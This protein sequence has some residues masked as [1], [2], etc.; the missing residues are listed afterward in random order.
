MYGEMGV[1]EER[2][3][4]KRKKEKKKNSM[5]KRDVL[6]R[7]ALFTCTL[8]FTVGPPRAGSASIA[9]TQSTQHGAQ[10]GRGACAGGW[11]RMREQ[12]CAGGSRG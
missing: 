8:T 4:W 11:E 6:K 3:T 10:A 9:L 2:E 1:T 7:Q 5:R 12:R